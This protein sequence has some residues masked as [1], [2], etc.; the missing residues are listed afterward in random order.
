M[1]PEPTLPAPR[2]FR[3]GVL[4]L[5]LVIAGPALVMIGG[6]YAMAAITAG[7]GQSVALNGIPGLT[8]IYTASP[9]AFVAGITLAII[10]VV[11]G[12]RGRGLGIAA[13]IVV[14]AVIVFV[15]PVLLYATFGGDPL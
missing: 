7:A 9:I 8:V 12:G 3:L 5:I 11:R 10:A 14:A 15:A 2:R 6:V 4:A 13:L 1:Q